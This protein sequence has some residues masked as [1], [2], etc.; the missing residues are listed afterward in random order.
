MSS[1]DTLRAAL[2]LPENADL[3]IETSIPHPP[4]GVQDGKALS[5]LSLAALLT[6]QPAFH[7]VGHAVFEGLGVEIERA[8]GNAAVIAVTPAPGVVITPVSVIGAL[9]AGESWI[10]DGRG[11]TAHP[12]ALQVEREDQIAYVLVRD[13]AVEVARLS[14][15]PS[16]LLHHVDLGNPPHA[17]TLFA[18]VVTP[19][20]LVAHVAELSTSPAP[21]DG[22]AAVGIAARL[23]S[24]PTREARRQ[25]LMTGDLP[26]L[27]RAR[28]W[29]R[30]LSPSTLMTILREA[31]AEVL[32]LNAMLDDLAEAPSEASQQAVA[33]T[34]ALR[35]EALEGVAWILAA[36]GDAR[37]LI[38]LLD[39]L[40]REVEV[41]RS[42]LPDPGALSGD[43]VL[44]A[45]ARLD[46]DAWWGGL[47]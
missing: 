14:P 18:G 17:D 7:A 29:A 15:G 45:V 47:S 44:E 27:V 19:A 46:S 34:L 5:R 21:L 40:D 2:G 11:A 26:P 22:V 32:D 37:P 16:T 13:G 10:L 20:W 23:W 24:P 36:S 25:A 1:V 33:R 12:V 43:P 35:R 39:D 4:S 31:A 41:H 6:T 8:E 9:P 42:E 30:S 28:E 38:A 3:Y